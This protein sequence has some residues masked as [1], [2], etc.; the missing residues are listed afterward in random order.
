MDLKITFWGVRGSKPTP[1]RDT[2]LFGGNTSCVQIETKKKNFIFDGGTGLAVLGKKMFDGG[3]AD[4]D[5]FFS[6]LHWDHIQGLPFFMPLYEE[7]NT[8]TLYG[9]DKKELSFEDAIINQMKAPYFPITMEM[10]KADYEFIGINTDEEFVFQDGTKISTFEV[11]HPSGCL[12]FKIEKG[13]SKVVYST[14]TEPMEG[15]RRGEFLEFI[16]GADILIYDTH[17]TDEEY[18]GGLCGGK[19]GWGH[20]TWEEGTVIS[21]EGNIGN[22]ILFHHKDDRSDRQQQ[23]IEVLAKQKFKNTIAAREGMVIIVGGDGL[24]KVVVDYPY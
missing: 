6:H 10:M 20:S 24:E 15:Q 9:Q 8:F 16:K 22:L 5:I 3:K 23:E 7:G 4:A 13:A 12:A 18:I 11:N 2:I 14:D 1:S 17:Y 19:K 21:K